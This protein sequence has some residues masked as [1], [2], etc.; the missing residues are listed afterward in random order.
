MFIE[1][2]QFSSAL[3]GKPIIATDNPPPELLPPY[4]R[5]R[6]NY[7]DEFNQ[8]III[9][10]VTFSILFILAFIAVILY[11]LI[12]RRLRLS[13]DELRREEE[14]QAY[15]ELN[16]DEQELYFQSKEYLAANPYING[17]LTMSQKLSIQ[18]KGINAFEF[19]KSQMLTHNDLTIL[20]KFELNFFKNF[21]CSTQTNLPIPMKNEVYYFETK[22]YNLPQPEETLI[23]IGL[24]IKPYPWFRLPG[25]HTHS[26]SYDSDGYRRYNQPFKFKTD[27]P[28][29]K[30]AQGDVVGIGYR[31]RSGTVFFTRNGKKVSESKVGGHIRNFKI[32][33]QGQIYP[34]IGANNICS[35]HVNLGQR[36]FVFIEGNVK[37]WGYAP[38]EGSG[39]APPAYRKFN[40]DILL[41]RSEVDDDN[42]DLSERE[43]DFPPEFWEIHGGN[44]SGSGPSPPPI[45][46]DKFSYNAYS[47]VGS[48]DER[49]TLDTL[50][51]PHR[52][53]SYDEEI[54][55]GS[56]STQDVDVAETVNLE[57]EDENLESEIIEENDENHSNSRVEIEE[58]I[59]S[60]NIEPILELT[61][62]TPE[63][64][65]EDNSIEQVQQD[66]SNN[67][68][69]ES[70]P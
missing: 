40:S 42:N 57:L 51:I 67:N 61:D 34:I 7:D 17:E 10:I 5:G 26:I 20:N 31:T 14:N 18:E 22:I 24:A 2:V 3:S 32:Q 30:L 64:E 27:P 33:N 13:E 48:C 21:E 35:L 65:A 44:E 43:D 60:D 9:S 39:P 23:S 28:F 59:E 12:R 50:C 16:S 6:Q 58:N 49:I 46:H 1:F 68:N 19:Q 55:V 53:P 25:R 56:S 54:E 62:D 47:E 69:E 36:G 15:L 66:E 37:S 29:P 70:Q 11:Y 8:F 45:E 41:E 63:G 4:G 38:L 52:P